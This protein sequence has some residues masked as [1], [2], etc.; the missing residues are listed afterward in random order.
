MINELMG[1]D[2]DYLC[3][4]AVGASGGVLIG[5]RRNLW[6]GSLMCARRFSVSVRLQPV[7]SDETEAWWLSGR[8]R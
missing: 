3:L 6:S 5:W 1:T 8:T 2:F 4:P 7:Q